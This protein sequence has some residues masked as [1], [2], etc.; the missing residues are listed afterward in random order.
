MARAD[1]TRRVSWVRAG[2]GHGHGGG[3]LWGRHLGIDPSPCKAGG[4][5]G[6]KQITL[7]LVPLEAALDYA[8]EDADIT[9]RLYLTLKPRLLAERMVTVYETIE[10]PLI[11]VLVAMERAGIAVDR[12]LLVA[13]PADFA[14]PLDV[15]AG[16]VPNPARP[17]AHIGPPK[18]RSAARSH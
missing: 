16:G 5:T 1:D 7:E 10:R 8:A 18:Q 6:K 15:L 2:G 11:P 14:G 12:K 9:G 17:Q 4:G 13:R 3:G